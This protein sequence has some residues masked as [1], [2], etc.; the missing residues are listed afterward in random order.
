[1][2]RGFGQ[3][4]ILLLY[5]IDHG[6]LPAHFGIL[7]QIDENAIL[8]PSGGSTGRDGQRAAMTSKQRKPAHCED[9]Q[10]IKVSSP[11]GPASNESQHTAKTGRT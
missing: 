9:W 2:I 7:Y 10:G 8:E 3:N 11:Q 4:N 5:T 1:M 6:M